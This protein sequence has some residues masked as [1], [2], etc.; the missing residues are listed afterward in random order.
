MNFLNR[1]AA[2]LLLAAACAAPVAADD[3]LMAR[4]DLMYPEAMMVLQSAIKAQ[5]YTITRLQ[6]VN[7]NL[8]KRHY[9]SDMY[10]VVFFGKYDEVKALAASHPELIPYLP[11]NI[12]I[13]AEGNNAIV[14][15]AHPRTLEEF[16]P[17]PKLKPIFERWE[18]DMVKIMDTVRESK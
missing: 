2:L 18:A 14:L 16:F 7:E 3:L 5:G 4:S 10:R 1:L 9:K 6:Q 8:A 12:T 13:F 11:L 17:D 15:T